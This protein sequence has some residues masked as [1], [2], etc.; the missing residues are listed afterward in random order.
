MTP[1]I[2]SPWLRFT[3]EIEISLFAT[4][5]WNF[6]FSPAILLNVGYYRQERVKRQR[7]SRDANISSSFN[8][9]TMTNPVMNQISEC[10][11]NFCNSFQNRAWEKLTIITIEA[12]YAKADRYRQFFVVIGTQ[13]LEIFRLQLYVNDR[14]ESHSK[15][16]WNVCDRN[17]HFSTES[18]YSCSRNVR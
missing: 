8:K 2:F 11:C 7:N 16:R 17:R 9:M 12:C 1:E 6:S 14:R 5:P 18:P 3:T 10:L 15:G 4:M 13:L